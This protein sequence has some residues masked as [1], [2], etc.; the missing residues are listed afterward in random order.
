MWTLRWP[1]VWSN[2]TSASSVMGWIA[3]G[4]VDGLGVSLMRIT[5]D[6]RE[7]SY[8][9]ALGVLRRAYGRHRLAPKT[10]ESPAV[11]EAVDM[12]NGGALSEE[13][14]QAVRCW[15][16]S[17]GRGGGQ[18]FGEGDEKVACQGDLANQGSRRGVARFEVNE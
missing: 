12:S 11:G 4:G 7:D 3:G 15:R 17:Q 9:D 18:V 6:T 2:Q 13:S 5:I 16:R 8:Q 1:T 10:E 14:G